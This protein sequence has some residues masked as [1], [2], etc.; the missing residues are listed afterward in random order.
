MEYPLAV[1]SLVHDGTGFY[2][3]S[4]GCDQR[5]GIGN[6]NGQGVPTGVPAHFI[7]S[8]RKHRKYSEPE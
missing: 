3:G 4:Y 1:H 6:N 7:S 5:P 2:L 8:K